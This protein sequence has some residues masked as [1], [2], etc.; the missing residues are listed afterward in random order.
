MKKTLVATALALSAL[1]LAGTAQASTA[2]DAK[3]DVQRMWSWDCDHD[4]SEDHTSGGGI[5]R[6]WYSMV[7]CDLLSIS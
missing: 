2:G 4:G 3:A 1:N 5:M 7:N 6:A